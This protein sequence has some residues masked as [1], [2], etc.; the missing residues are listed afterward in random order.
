MMNVAEGMK[1]KNK[2]RELHPRFTWVQ[3]QFIAHV[4]RDHT[5]PRK[6]GEQEKGN[7]PPRPHRLAG[8]RLIRSDREKNKIKRSTISSLVGN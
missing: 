4:C 8:G 6:G 7:S 3:G 1:G 2:N 5:A